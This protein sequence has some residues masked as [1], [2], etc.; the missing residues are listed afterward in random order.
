MGIMKC[1]GRD[2][3]GRRIYTHTYVC[4]HTQL[5]FRICWFCIHRLNQPWI[6][7]M[8]KNLIKF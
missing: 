3:I 8:K 2:R 1:K 4:T 7:N 6:K 5:A